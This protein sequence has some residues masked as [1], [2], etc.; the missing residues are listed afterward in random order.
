MNSP[1]SPE[2]HTLDEYVRA[3]W[4][5]LKEMKTTMGTDRARLDAVERAVRD[6]Q[7]FTT[8]LFKLL[9]AVAVAVTIV[10]LMT[11]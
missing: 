8:W 2:P 3:I 10:G 7:V 6:L 9:P 4:H 11:R 1:F 5:D